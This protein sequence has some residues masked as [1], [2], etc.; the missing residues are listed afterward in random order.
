MDR[1]RFGDWKKSLQEDERSSLYAKLYPNTPSH[2]PINF[3]LI[4]T[5]C[6]PKA[7]NAGRLHQDNCQ[8]KKGL[9]GNC[10]WTPMY[11]HIPGCVHL[12]LPIPIPNPVPFFPDEIHL[13]FCKEPPSNT[14]RGNSTKANNGAKWVDL[15][16]SARTY[17]AKECW[18]CYFS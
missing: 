12:L 9:Q 2:L 14:I 4:P 13:L 5:M 7:A 15:M 16:F 11:T 17:Q 18:M 1:S 8:V 10:A 6:S 3:L